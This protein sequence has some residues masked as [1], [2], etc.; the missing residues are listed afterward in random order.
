MEIQKIAV[1][2]VELI[3][4]SC[5]QEIHFFIVDISKLMNYS[6]VKGRFIS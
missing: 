1:I 3:D 2:D 5:I 6:Q 4:K